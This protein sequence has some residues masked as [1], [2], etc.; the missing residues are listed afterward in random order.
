M[1]IMETLDVR[2]CEPCQGRRRQPVR[3]LG[4]PKQESS[5][6]REAALFHDM[7]PARAGYENYV[8]DQRYHNAV[9]G[10]INKMGNLFVQIRIVFST[11][12]TLH[13]GGKQACHKL[14]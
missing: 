4:L 1:G 14:F 8:T 2:M 7:E 6:P 11:V 5:G 3:T 13:R 12:G 10:T 9:D